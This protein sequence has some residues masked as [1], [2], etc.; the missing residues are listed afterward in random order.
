MSES[1]LS[2]CLR[3]ELQDLEGKL[4]LEAGSGAG[5]FSEILLRQGAILHSFD[6]SAA[7]EA[8]AANNGASDRLTLI[9]ADILHIPFPPASYDYVI[10]LGV[11]QHTPSPEES[12]RSLWK[13]VRP[14]G[15]L[16]VDHYRWNLWLR[17]PPPLGDAEKLYRWIVLR[18]P[19]HKR[20]AA[21]RAITRFW[22]PIYWRFRESRWARRILARTAGIH[23][24]YGIFDLRDRE[25]HLQ[26]ALLDTH[27][28][29]T[30][31]YKHYRTE[32]QIR[33]VLE[34]LGA[35]DIRVDEGGNG[36]EAYCRKPMDAS[37]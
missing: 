28:G 10:C 14:G 2:R 29:M 17:L 25:E 15:R 16:V 24:Y 27:D 13:M 5:R 9:Q 1:R 6:Y 20:L 4:V 35:E 36:V 7:V 18:L 31:H 32:G 26:W 34:E 8:N 3:G 11:L 33:Q 19:R 30:D 22:F 21:T 37:G 23:F 12:I